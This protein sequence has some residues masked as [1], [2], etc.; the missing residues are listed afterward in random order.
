MPAVVVL[1]ACNKV[2][3]RYH[4]PPPSPSP[5]SPVARRVTGRAVAAWVT[6]CGRDCRAARVKR[7]RYHAPPAPSPRPSP[8][9]LSPVVGRMWAQVTEY[10]G[11]SDRKR[12]GASDRERV[13]A[14]DGATYRASFLMLPDGTQSSCFSQEAPIRHPESTHRCVSTNTSMND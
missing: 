13:G 1:A 6:G 7:G 2:V 10:V 12:V 5:L 11:A 9:P 14:S 4:F 3:I 8:S